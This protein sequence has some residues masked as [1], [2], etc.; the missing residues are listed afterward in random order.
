MRG[1]FLENLRG[2]SS[3]LAIILFSSDGTFEKSLLEFNFKF[4]A[5]S[6]FFSGF[7]SLIYGFRIRS[8]TV[9]SATSCQPDSNG[10]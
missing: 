6:T 3:N 9:P 10:V 7:G 1:R 2:F 5:T 8:S 4:S